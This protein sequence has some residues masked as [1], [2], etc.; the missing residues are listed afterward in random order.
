MVCHLKFE[1]AKFISNPDTFVIDLIRYAK[2][3]N[4]KKL[5]LF[6][7]AGANLNSRTSAGES[8]AELFER[9]EDQIIK[10]YLGSIGVC[11]EVS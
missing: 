10:E 11:S 3:G 7:N 9:S 2:S 1:G 8:L 6:K 5:K 4:I